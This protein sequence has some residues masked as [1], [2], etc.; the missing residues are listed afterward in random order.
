MIIFILAVQR[1]GVYS[2]AYHWTRVRKTDF[3]KLAKLKFEVY[4]NSFGTLKITS[5]RPQ[6]DL[7]VDLRVRT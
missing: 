1:N 5:V 7:Q 6:V 2:R 3:F 4:S